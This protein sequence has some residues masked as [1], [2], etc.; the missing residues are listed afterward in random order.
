MISTDWDTISQPAIHDYVE[1]RYLLGWFANYYDDE[2]FTL[3]PY[4][5][6]NAKNADR[7][8]NGLTYRVIIERKHDSSP[9]SDDFTFELIVNNPVR[10]WEH[11]PFRCR[12]HSDPK[13]KQYVRD[14]A[15]YIASYREVH[16]GSHQEYDKMGLA[17]SELY[18]L[19]THW[20]V[21]VRHY[22][23]AKT[24]FVFLLRTKEF[25]REV[26]RMLLNDEIDI[27]RNSPNKHKQNYV[28]VLCWVDLRK[29]K[30]GVAA[31]WNITDPYKLLVDKKEIPS[32]FDID[33]Y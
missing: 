29:L 18:G 22:R 19:N 1:K 31:W 26:G 9:K 14:I 17:A 8:A 6:P 25:Q 28:N 24:T 27:G 21:C 33:K 7:I 13:H 32:D 15:K 20:T 5:D 10:M 16:D 12:R 23:Q 2:D 30:K 4:S 11:L 3:E